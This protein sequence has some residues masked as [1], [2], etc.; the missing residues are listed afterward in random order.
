MHHF[1]ITNTSPEQKLETIVSAASSMKVAVSVGLAIIF[2]VIIDLL[3]TRQI[4]PNYRPTEIIFFIVLETDEKTVPGEPI[5]S[6]LLYESSD[7]HDGQIIRKEVKPD[8]TAFL[9]M[10]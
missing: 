7:K 5:Q 9:I 3:V 4:L 1:D 8:T 2:L 6:S 10:R